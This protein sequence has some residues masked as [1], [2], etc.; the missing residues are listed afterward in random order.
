MNDSHDAAVKSRR[1]A[2]I[3]SEL[4]GDKSPVAKKQQTASAAT[5]AQETSNDVIDSE[6]LEQ[7]ENQLKEQAI[8]GTAAVLF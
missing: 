6:I 7:Q 5:A 8:A 4:K 3:K 1:T 2:Y